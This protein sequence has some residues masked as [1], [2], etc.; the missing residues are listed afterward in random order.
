[1]SSDSSQEETL[2]NRTLFQEKDEERRT[3]GICGPK[4][5]ELLSGLNLGGSS[6]KMLRVLMTALESLI[7]NSATWKMRATS[8]CRRLKFRQELMGRI[9]DDI[10][11][12]FLPPIRKSSHK[13]CPKDRYW[14]SENYRSM[15]T[16]AALR[17]S[18]D[19]PIYLT[20]DFAEALQGFPITW[21]ELKDSETP[22]CR[23]KFTQS[24]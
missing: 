22:S 12:S 18:P 19:D 6:T 8:R 7:V 9:P 16:I 24:S 2:A 1:M 4:C 20:L 23:N 11:P 5:S 10:E 14:G 17:E 13:G 21:T 3:P 15:W